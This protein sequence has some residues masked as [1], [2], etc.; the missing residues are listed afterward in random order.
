MGEPHIGE[1]EAPY[2]RL[3]YTDWLRA[4]VANIMTNVDFDGQQN[5]NP[6]QNNRLRDILQ[7]FKD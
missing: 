6:E 3:W 2:D 5:V 4:L 7:V 1:Q